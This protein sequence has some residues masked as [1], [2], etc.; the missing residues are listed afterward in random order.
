M[1]YIVFP[2]YPLQDPAV[3]S[4]APKVAP[5]GGRPEA[6]CILREPQRPKAIS[7]SLIC[8]NLAVAQTKVVPN[9]RL[10]KWNQQLKP[11]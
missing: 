3:Q 4:K 6:K 8:S 7:Q 1:G 10:G 5:K 9:W 11:A 2:I